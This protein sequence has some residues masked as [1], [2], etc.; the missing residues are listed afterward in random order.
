MAASCLPG[1]LFAAFLHE[2]SPDFFASIDEFSEAADTFALADRLCACW[3]EGRP[4]GQQFADLYA[5]PLAARGLAYAKRQPKSV[6]FRPLRRPE[7]LSLAWSGAG[8]NPRTELLEMQPFQRSIARGGRQLA[9]GKLIL[10]QDM[11]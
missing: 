8:R 3:Q 1:A 10:G 5:G 2:N 4:T 11:L 6:G 9:F 7:L